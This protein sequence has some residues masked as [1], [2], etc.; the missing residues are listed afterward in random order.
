MPRCFGPGV[1]SRH[2]KIWAVVQLSQTSIMEIWKHLVI[3]RLDQFTLL[4]LEKVFEANVAEVHWVMRNPGGSVYHPGGLIL[5][6]CI[7]ESFMENLHESQNWVWLLQRTIASIIESSD[8]C[9]IHEVFNISLSNI[10]AFFTKGNLD[11]AKPRGHTAR[12]LLTQ[13][14][15]RVFGVFKVLDEFQSIVHRVCTSHIWIENSINKHA[16]RV[17]T[18]WPIIGP[19]GYKVQCI[20]QI[21]KALSPEQIVLLL[22]LS[23]FITYRHSKNQFIYCNSF[24]FLWKLAQ[25]RGIH[26]FHLTFLTLWICCK[27]VPCQD[28]IAASL[29]RIPMHGILLHASFPVFR[30]VEKG[31]SSPEVWAN[32]PPL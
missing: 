22:F 18:C 31:Q 27:L 20:S 5:K 2:L 25:I 24:H 12:L 15:V 30:R 11:V 6:T 29:V 7:A 8:S 4:V 32:S 9:K 14:Y 17:L 13:R 1:V 10:A 16:A 21:V 23:T 3:H 26:T 28:L 19:I